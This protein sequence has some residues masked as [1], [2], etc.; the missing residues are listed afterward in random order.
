M[1]EK[2]IALV[3]NDHIGKLAYK[4][5]LHHWYGLSKNAEEKKIRVNYKK[6]GCLFEAFLGAL[7]QTSILG[8]ILVAPWLPFGAPWGPFGFLWVPFGLHWAPFGSLWALLGLILLALATIFAQFWC[9]MWLGHC[10]FGHVA[11]K[12]IFLH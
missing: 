7:F 4:M 10:D 5:G 8:R 9:P 11:S 3:N 1:T 2:K 12:T 6:L